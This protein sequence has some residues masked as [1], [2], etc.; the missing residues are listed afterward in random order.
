[1]P[2]EYDDGEPYPITYQ[3]INSGR[4]HL[5]THKALPVSCPIRLL[6]GTADVDVPWKLSQRVLEGVN[7]DNATL[8]LIRHGDHR[9]SDA[10]QL[11]EIECQLRQLR[12][13]IVN[14]K[15]I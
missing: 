5:L 10:S 3:L 8:T 11:A 12:T 6:H 15:Q 13:T 1:M 14:N 2:T 9:L 4:E 7:S